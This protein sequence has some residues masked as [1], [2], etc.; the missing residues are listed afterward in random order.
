M[1]QKNLLRVAVVMFSIFILT[2]SALAGDLP[3]IVSTDWLE[4]N[5]KNAKL[6][7][8]DVRKVEYYQEG[9]IPGAVNDFYRA[10]SFKK[11]DLSAE[12]PDLD[13]LF[14]LVGSAGI[15]PDSLV[16]IVGKMDTWQ[17]R[18]HIARVACTLNYASVANVALLDGG[19]IKWAREGRRL[20]TETVKPKPVTFKGQINRNIFVKKDYILKNLDKVLLVDVRE[21]AFFKGQKKAEVAAKAGRIPGAVNLP[22]S[23]VF[24]KEGTFKSKDVLQSLAEGVIGKDREREII[25]YCDTGTCCPTWRFMLREVLGY[26]RVYLYDGSIEEWTADPSV[27]VQ[28]DNNGK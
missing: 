7:V 13:D 17:E 20:S 16:V 14:E 22:T 9:H 25:T 5:L 6:I 26:K 19:H 12:V 28:L 1:S 10:W 18:V 8:L 3:A 21:P 2:L 27:P 15:S 4:K 23:W 11:A 24:E